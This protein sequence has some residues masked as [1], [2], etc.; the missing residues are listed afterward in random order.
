MNNKIKNT[1]SDRLNEIDIMV[2][3][4]KPNDKI[5]E[6]IEQYSEQL[7]YFDYIKTVEEFSLLK[8]C[9]TI[10]YI[11]KYDGELRSGGLLIKIYSKNNNW[12]GIIKQPKKCYHVSFKSNYI[13][14]LKSK[15]DELRSILEQ[16]EKKFDTGEYFILEN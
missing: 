10:K 12:Y 5:N 7:K 16:F 4:I 8:L 15:Q 11:N 1:Y 13:F 3:K 9:G 2:D 14:Y 6:L